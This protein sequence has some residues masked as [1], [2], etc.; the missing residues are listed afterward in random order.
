MASSGSDLQVTLKQF[1]AEAS[2]MTFSTS[3]SET[4]VP[5]Q[6]KVECPLKVWVK[7][8]SQIEVFKYLGILFTTEA[9][10]EHR[11]YKQIIPM[12]Y[13]KSCADCLLV[14]LYFY[15]YLWS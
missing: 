12:W 10:M 3:N 7:L 15:C 8:L 14:N 11:T 5:S 13:R 9:K 2:G 4:M 6:K 1:V